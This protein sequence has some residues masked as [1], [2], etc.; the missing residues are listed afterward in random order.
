MTIDELAAGNYISLAT[1]KRD[2]TRVA[3]PVWV[4]RDGEHL[5]VI[6]DT[7]SGK[8]KRL[9]NSSTAEIAPCDI[10]G[11]TSADPVAATAILLDDPGTT[12]VLGL[13]DKKYG[14]Q[15]KVFGLMGSPGRLVGRGDEK[16]V[17]IQISLE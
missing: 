10:R 4:T 16:R 6:T 1:F 13:V 3:T 7:D 11:H 9:R 15:A 12:K 2:G 8:A 14:L 17:G 5:Y